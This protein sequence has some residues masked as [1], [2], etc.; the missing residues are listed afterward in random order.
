MSTQC[1]HVQVPL[2]AVIVVGLGFFISLAFN[3]CQ[4]RQFMSRTISLVCVRLLLNILVDNSL[5]F[6]R[7]N[8]KA[9]MY[10][11]WRQNPL[12]RSAFQCRFVLQS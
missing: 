8:K 4:W 10:A 11:G 12:L 2:M 9:H 1:L 5:P 3:I 6:D 7:S